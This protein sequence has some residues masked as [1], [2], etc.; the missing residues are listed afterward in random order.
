MINEQESIVESYL[1]RIVEQND[2]I[3]NLL[4][5]IAAN[6][7]PT[8]NIEVD[9]SKALINKMDSLTKGERQVLDLLMQGMMNKEMAYNLSLSLSTI[10]ARRSSV[11][12]KMEAKNVAQLTVEYMKYQAL[13]KF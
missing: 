8:A 2:T 9:E 12:K 4:K 3:I 13:M 1:L 7:T 10:E 5:T 11:M 6:T